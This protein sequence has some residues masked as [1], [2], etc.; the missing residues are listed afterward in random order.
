[1]GPNRP[2]LPENQG[3]RVIQ[4]RDEGLEEHGPRDRTAMALVGIAFLVVPLAIIARG[5]LPPD[6]VMRHA[7][8][9]VMDRTW[10]DV[11]V[12]RPE[13]LFDTSPGWHLFLRAVHRASGWGPEGLATFS[14]LELALFFML[15]GLPL[16]RRWES[17]AAALGLMFLTDGVL[18]QRFTL[19][20]PF[21]LTS[22]TVMVLLGTSRV[23]DTGPFGRRH[24][25][26]LGLAALSTW[27]HGSWYLMAMAPGILA[28][29]GRIREALRM[30]AVLAAGVLLGAC[31][32]GHPWG[33]L[34]G[35]IAHLRSALGQTPDPRDLVMELTPGRQSLWPLA[36]V[37]AAGACALVRTR[38]L[39]L[40]REPALLL[41]LLTWLLGYAR[42]WRF[43][44]DF[45]FPLLAL[46]MAWA[47]DEAAE[48]LPC[49]RGQALA[50]C[51][52][53]LAGTLPNRHGR[54][55]VNGA[56]GGLDGRLP[57]QASLLPDPGGI[58]YSNSMYV[59]YQTFY[60]NPEGRWRYILAYEP[61]MMR[62]EDRAV[63]QALMRGEDLGK[64]VAP[65]LARMT[66]RDRMILDVRVAHQPPIPGLIWTRAGAG[67]WSGRL[68]AEGP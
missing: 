61:G 17:W 66:P 68:P 58:L 14:I 43:Y 41:G 24:A 57:A 62:A 53:L 56:R 20:R 13:A 47:L 38:S 42:V 33:Y 22:V 10:A 31:L 54:W 67:R 1:M 16:V 26:W 32:T 49:R 51:A 12:G 64:A 29:S 3:R 35:H 2:N 39:G 55:S 18:I 7:A 6:D 37:L 50:A 34:A 40:L 15:S 36:L 46:W 63:Y 4:G 45:S 59:F 44:M 27:V 9:A 25:V 23:R 30:A 48:G 5:Y 52:I 60:L 65:W 8:F 19:G 21:V 11:I 28:L